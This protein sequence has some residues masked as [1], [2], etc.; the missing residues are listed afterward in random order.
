MCGLPLSVVHIPPLLLSAHCRRAAP[1]AQLETRGLSSVGPSPVLFAE[2]LWW[3]ISFLTSSCPLF[4]ISSTL[5]S[6][7]IASHIAF[8]LVM[9]IFWSCDSKKMYLVLTRTPTIS[10]LNYHFALSLTFSIVKLF[11]FS[12]Q[13]KPI[14]IN[15]GSQ[16]K[17]WRKEINSKMLLEV[18]N[19]SYH[20]SNWRDVWS[21][22][23]CGNRSLFGT[24]ANQAQ[25]VSSGTL[26]TFAQHETHYCHPACNLGTGKRWL[27]EKVQSV[28][29]TLTIIA[30][31]GRARQNKNQKNTLWCCWCSAPMWICLGAKGA[32]AL[33]E[34]LNVTQRLQSGPLNRGNQSRL[35]MLAVCDIKKV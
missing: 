11:F 19:A 28:C 32:Q 22:T 31:D 10:G 13:I 7:Q 5:A 16:T 25:R 2:V 30:N 20:P 24:S 12:L 18:A 17:M 33:F 1:V 6:S 15:D 14:G 21:W 34:A 23:M 29:L 4:L 35:W 26:P 8:L 3:V 27:I 9:L